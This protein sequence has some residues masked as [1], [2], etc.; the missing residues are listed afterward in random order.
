[1]EALDD[2]G[3][4]AK[5]LIVLKVVGA[6]SMLGFNNL[7]ISPAPIGFQLVRAAFGLFIGGEIIGSLQVLH[8]LFMGQVFR[9][10]RIWCTIQR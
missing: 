9:E 6:A 7:R 8:K 5:V 2:M 10:F 4:T 1:M 3:C